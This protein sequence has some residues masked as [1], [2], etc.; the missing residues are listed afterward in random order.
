MRPMSTPAASAAKAKGKRRAAGSIAAD[1]MLPRPATKKPRAAIK[2]PATADFR[3]VGEPS[4]AAAGKAPVECS[5][6]GG[7]RSNLWRGLWQQQRS[8][9]PF[10]PFAPEREGRN[11]K[12]IKKDRQLAGQPVQQTPRQD[13]DPGEEM[14]EYCEDEAE[15]DSD[16]FEDG[17]DDD[18]TA[19]RQEAQLKRRSPKRKGA[20]AD[21]EAVGMQSV[22]MRGLPT[23]ALARGAGGFEVR[24]LEAVAVA[25]NTV[26]ADDA[27]PCRLLVTNAGTGVTER[28][29]VLRICLP[30]C[31]PLYVIRHCVV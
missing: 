30:V 31:M 6:D 21:A 4:G 25:G 24:A 20:S 17:G 16:A 26:R 22:A 2:A 9:K 10:V 12:A 29:Q 11:D 27:L 5:L 8:R 7:Q 14:D 18:G 23:G 1:G 19:K 13:P 3:E 15:D 28:G